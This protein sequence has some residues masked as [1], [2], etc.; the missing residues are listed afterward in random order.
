MRLIKAALLASMA[1]FL[2]FAV[3]GHVTMPKTGINAVAAALSMEGTFKEPAAMARA[4][5]DPS[6]VRILFWLIAATE[7][8]AAALCWLGS[9]DLTLKLGSDAA[10]FNKAKWL[11]L[12]GLG[13][14][15]LLYIAG[16]H[17]IAGE[18][19]L[20]W[21]N[22]QINVL[23]DAFRNATTALLLMIL[24]GQEDR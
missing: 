9:L 16:F 8:I 13:L 1:L 18:W 22:A 12:W 17:A 10:A 11:G 19:F 15:A 7:A 5:T 2:T 21:Q 4:I 23:P 3:I 20:M 24:I 6:L 14:S